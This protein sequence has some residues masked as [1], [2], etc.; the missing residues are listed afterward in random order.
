M[1]DSSEH[2]IPNEKMFVLQD[3]RQ[4]EEVHEFVLLQRQD[5]SKP[6]EN[7]IPEQS[8]LLQGFGLVVFEEEDEEDEEGAVT[9]LSSM[10]SCCYP[11]PSYRGQTLQLP[12]PFHTTESTLNDNDTES[13]YRNGMF[14]E[15]RILECDKTSP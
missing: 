11:N 6:S 10:K 3:L 13:T 1:H 14:F 12:E 5:L 4:T 2:V 9:D 8:T 15:T 7:M